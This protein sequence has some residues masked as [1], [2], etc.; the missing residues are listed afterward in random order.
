MQIVEVEFISLADLAEVVADVIA[1]LVDWHLGV[2]VTQCEFRW[3]DEQTVGRIPEVC[4]GLVV[5]MLVQH[6]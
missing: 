6:V 5:E 4:L 1:H 3:T 2:T